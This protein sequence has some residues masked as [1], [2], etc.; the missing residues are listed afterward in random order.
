[1]ENKSPKEN[2]LAPTMSDLEHAY[3]VHD[4]NL[5]GHQT[6]RDVAADGSG[7][8]V[9]CSANPKGDGEHTWLIRIANDGTVGWQH[10]YPADQGAGRAIVALPTGGYAIAG[11]IQ[12]S[13]MAYQGYLLRADAGGAAVTGAAFGPAGVT[14]F[15][16]VTVLGDGSILAGGSASDHGWLVRVDSALHASWEMPLGGV[17]DVFGL[18]PLTGG[19]FAMVALRELSTVE[20]DFTQFAAFAGNRHVLW[21]KQLPTTGRGEPAALAA[22]PDGGLVAV[23]RHSTEERRDPQ[24][25]VVRLSASGDVL[26]DKLIGDA[27]EIRIGAAIVALPDGGFAVAGAAQRGEHRGLRLARLSGDGAVLWERAYG[28]EQR[29]E[30]TGLAQTADGGFV[31]VGS[32]MSKGAGKTNVW[33]LKLDSDGQLVW[34]RAFGTA[35]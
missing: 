27:G 1:M 23:G 16:A 22:L 15:K 5:A 12:R 3:R 26:W 9:L 35:G 4:P 8:T 14:G 33:I 24:M 30:A 11:E 34:D 17:H 32:T 29:D 21:Q 10:H 25:W 18:A 28:G 19:G 6:A 31:L 20:L 7:I 2:P 13:A